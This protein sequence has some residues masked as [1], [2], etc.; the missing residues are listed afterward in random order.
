MSDS[1]R[2]YVWHHETSP[3]HERIAFALAHNVEEARQLILDYWN[4]PNE[5]S[6]YWY[7][8]ADLRIDGKPKVYTKPFGFAMRGGL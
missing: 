8:A 5:H 1:L 2:L 4:D 3:V 7:T 6:S